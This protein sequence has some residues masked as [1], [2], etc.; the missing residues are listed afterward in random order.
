MKAVRITPVNKFTPIKVEVTI[1]TQEE[2][3]AILRA[4]EV[5]C[6]DQINDAHSYTD[7]GLW[8]ETLDA[9]AQAVCGE[10]DDK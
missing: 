2:L 4:E 10:G 6:R 3:N 1:N 9:I 5:L 8:V 7:R